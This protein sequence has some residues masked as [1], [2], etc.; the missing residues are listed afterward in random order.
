MVASSAW[1]VHEEWNQALCE[2]I[3]TQDNAGSPV[4]LDMDEDV[5]AKVFAQLGVEGLDGIDRLAAAVR[6]TLR[7]DTGE[8]LFSAHVAR[9]QAWRRKIR[10][11]EGNF[12]VV[13][14]PPVIALLAVFTLAAEAMTA[15]SEH[16]ANAYYPRLCRLLGVEESAAK[17]RL[18]TA[19]RRHAE[20]L[21]RG[22]NDWLSAADGRYGL[23]TAY[24]LSHRYVGLPMSQALVRATDRR[25]FPRMFHQFGL[26]P[27]ADVPPGDMVHLLD[28]WIRQNPSPASKNI[29]ALW[30]DGSAQERIASVASVELLHWDGA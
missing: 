25:G 18:E 5:Q 2:V 3:F 27:G 13:D 20:T 22:L 14:R 7:M 15:D 8:A 17:R 11:L 10:S 24:A 16:R 4:Y 9:L 1:A 6:N 23:P 12:E 28:V 26:P 30:R 21:W 29:Q 19:Y